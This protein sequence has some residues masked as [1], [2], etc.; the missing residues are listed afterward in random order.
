MSSRIGSD[1]RDR[2]K[3][4]RERERERGEIG[5]VSFLARMGVTTFVSADEACERRMG[6]NGAEWSEVE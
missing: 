5:G 3:I 6:R 1:E 4:E 2:R